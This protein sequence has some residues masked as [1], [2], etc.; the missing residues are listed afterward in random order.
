M[1]P[2]SYATEIFCVFSDIDHA[3][4]VVAVGIF[5]DLNFE[6]VKKGVI[7]GYNNG[8]FILK[9]ALAPRQQNPLVH[10]NIVMI[11]IMRSDVKAEHNVAEGRVRG[12]MRDFHIPQ[13]EF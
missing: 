12:N 1:I 10:H 5:G 8:V 9:N 3:G 11:G 4:S 2:K 7:S 6:F 13:R